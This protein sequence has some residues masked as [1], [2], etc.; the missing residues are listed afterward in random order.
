MQQ[1]TF[2]GAKVIFFWLYCQDVVPLHLEVIE[3]IGI[4][5][6][7]LFKKQADKEGFI[8]EDLNQNQE[9]FKI[10]T[11][12][13]DKSIKRGDYLVRETSHPCIHPTYPY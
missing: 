5:A 6:Q 12:N 3:K 7:H 11:N 1:R 13:V 4:R 8:L 10:Y 9:S 2:V